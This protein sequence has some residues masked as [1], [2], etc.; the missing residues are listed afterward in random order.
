MLWGDRR[1]LNQWSRILK[2]K[3]RTSLLLS[4]I[5]LL[6]IAVNA[7]SIDQNNSSPIVTN[8]NTFNNEWQQQITDGIGGLLS[9]VNLYSFG[10]PGDTVQVRIGVGSSF[11]SG[12]YSFA[13]T[14]PLSPTAGAATFVDV[15][16]AGI[17]LAP[18][19]K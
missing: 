12:T 5:A 8:L 17:R 13:T 6:P 3:M 14:A 9:G 2:H 15:S 18:G 4:I 11:F 10:G 16:G 19:E 7:S 1:K